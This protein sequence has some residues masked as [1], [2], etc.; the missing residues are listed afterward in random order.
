M[1]LL[2][3]FPVFSLDQLVSRTYPMGLRDSYMASK[4]L[5]ILSASIEKGITASFGGVALET[6]S[7]SAKKSRGVVWSALKLGIKRFTDFFISCLLIL[8]ALPV[9][10]IIG[11]AIKATT[12]GPVFYRQERVGHRGNVFRIWK[13]STMI[14]DG[15]EEEHREYVQYLLGDGMLANNKID[16]LTRY[17]EFVNNKT[18]P[19]GRFL[20]STSL[21]ELPQL[22]NIFLGEMSLVGPRPHPVYEVNAYKDWYRRRLEVK[23]GLTGWSKLNLRCTPRNYE[24][25]ILYDL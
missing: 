22:L 24:E 13:F 25:S 8:F 14:Q 7:L 9:I 19:I 4:L 20:R 1:G 11:I 18:T 3:S 2:H 23:P 16:L 10:I 21:D 6:Q 5:R 12:T 15:T 17:I